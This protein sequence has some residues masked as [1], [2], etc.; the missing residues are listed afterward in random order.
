MKKIKTAYD[1]AD[2]QSSDGNAEKKTE[3]TQQ[4]MWRKTGFDGDW[5]SPE[6]IESQ[7]DQR[8]CDCNQGDEAD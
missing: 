1:K 4:L 5:S 2:H 3:H 7:G 8:H 6:Q